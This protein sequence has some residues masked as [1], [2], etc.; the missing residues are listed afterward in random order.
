[1]LNES[2]IEKIIN[3]LIYKSNIDRGIERYVKNALGY[4]LS[5]NDLEYIPD[6]NSLSSV[7]D[8]LVN[9]INY[10][11]SVV[12]RPKLVDIKSDM[13]EEIADSIIC[14]IN[15]KNIRALIGGE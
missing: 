10:I 9:I 14:S 3:G 5:Y 13:I 6:K 15:A 7:V 4:L 8:A 2:N 11:D 1:M 12:K